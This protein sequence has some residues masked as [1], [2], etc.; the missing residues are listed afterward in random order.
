M[1]DLYT[2]VVRTVKKKYIVFVKVIRREIDSTASSGGQ[3][4]YMKYVSF[5]CLPV[6]AAPSIFNVSFFLLRRFFGEG[7][8]NNKE[9]PTN[10]ES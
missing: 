3:W 8:K 1:H 5:L 7:I 4:S 2:C 10:A 6:E 9:I